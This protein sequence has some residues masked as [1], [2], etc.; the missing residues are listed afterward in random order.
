MNS[1][2]NLGIP[3]VGE[4]IFESIGTHELVKYLAVSQ[5]WKTLSETV[6]FQRWKG[7]ITITKACKNGMTEVVK[8]LLK[9]SKEESLADIN[10]KYWL[11]RD[12][13]LLAC[14]NG[15]HNI[16]KFLLNFSDREEINFH[17]EDLFGHTGLTYGTP[18]H[19]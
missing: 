4:Q 1:I 10:S 17:T 2:I 5:S 12:G 8:I 16:V 19:K 11:G 9:Y 3:H 18:K 7:N 15:H 14:K 6:L 13:F